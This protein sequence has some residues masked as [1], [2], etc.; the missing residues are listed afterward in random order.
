MKKA[1]VLAAC[2]L[3]TS[4]AFAGGEIQSKRYVSIPPPVQTY[5]YYQPAR[6]GVLT[7]I[8]NY[9]KNVWRDATGFVFKGA[10]FAVGTVTL[11]V[12]DLD[13]NDVDQPVFFN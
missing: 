1:L 11:G 3:I 6:V 7:R 4:T 9:G 10:D 13:G 2:L 8:G 5:E 12:V